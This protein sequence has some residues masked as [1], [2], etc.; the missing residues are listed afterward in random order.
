MIFETDWTLKYDYFRDEPLR[1]DEGVQ[2]Y[3]AASGANLAPGGYEEGVRDFVNPHPVFEFQWGLGRIVQ[4]LV[5]AGL[6]IE[7]LRE[8]PYVN[9]WK[10]F[11]RMR[12]GEG[13]RVYPPEGIPSI[14]MMYAIAARAPGP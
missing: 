1:W 10:G 4:A 5:N 11:E 3:V 7:T 9:G 6:A 2:D 8:Y 14:P 12:E 13:R